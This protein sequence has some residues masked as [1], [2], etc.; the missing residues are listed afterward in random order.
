M[1]LR[2]TSNTTKPVF[3]D[4]DP[5]FTRNPKTSDLL[6]VR[7]DGAVRLSLKN[8]LS[9]AFG[10]RLFQPT[11]GGSLRPLL[12]EP[13]DAVTTMEIRDRILLTIRQHEPRVGK[14]IVDVI[15][16]SDENHYTVNV[17]YSVLAVG[18]VD[19]LSVVLERVR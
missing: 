11:I 2:I 17:E 14:V 5:N 16:N 12:F 19:R 13:I 6:T 4:I 18:K 15:A 7:D 1:A 3:S 9:T 10:E 8:L